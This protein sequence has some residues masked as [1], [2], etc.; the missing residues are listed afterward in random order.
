V[1]RGTAEVTLNAKV[2]PV[3]ENESIYRSARFID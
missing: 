1:V 3:H 2:Q